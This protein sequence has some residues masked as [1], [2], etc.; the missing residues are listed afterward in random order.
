MLG[1]HSLLRLVPGVQAHVDLV[2]PHQAA[3][4]HDPSLVLRVVAGLQHHLGAAGEGDQGQAEV[5][6]LDLAAL[7]EGPLLVAASVVAGED[8]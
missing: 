4:A 3:L 7:G 8:A 5:V 2:V 6:V 1:T